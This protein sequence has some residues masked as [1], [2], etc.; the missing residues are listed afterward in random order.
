MNMPQIGKALAVAAV[1]AFAASS[2][3][4]ANDGILGATSQGDLEI[5]LTINDLV[6]ITDLDDIAL[7]TYTPGVNMTGD[8]TGRRS[9]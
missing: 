1:A 3:F 8:D 5:T 4:A 7:G 6:L 2:A 9:R